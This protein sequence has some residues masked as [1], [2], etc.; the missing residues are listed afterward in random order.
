MP[1]DMSENSRRMLSQALQGQGPMT[2]R[3]R[4]ALANRQAQQAARV[5]QHIQSELGAAVDPIQAAADVGQRA[6][7]AAVPAYKQA[8]NQ[9]LTVSQEMQDIMGTPIFQTKLNEQ[10][11]E[12]AA[13]GKDPR[14]F[15]FIAQPGGNYTFGE[16]PSLEAVDK[17]IRKINK[18]IPRDAFGKPVLDSF[19]YSLHDLGKRMDGATREANPLFDIA[20]SNY[21][22]EM[23]IRQA[24]EQGQKVGRYSGHEINA[25]TRSMPEHAQE[26]WLSGASSAFSD[27]A[28]EKGLRPTANVAADTQRQIGLPGAGLTASQGDAVK[29]EALE[30][31]TGRPGSMGRLGDRLEMEDAAHQTFAAAQRGR[32]GKPDFGQSSGSAD[33]L[34]AG[35][36]LATGDISGALLSAFLRG[37]PKGTG[38]FKQEVQEQIADTLS[39]T[40]PQAVQRVMQAIERQT[41]ADAA[42]QARRGT[43]AVQMGRAG[44][45]QLGGLDGDPYDPR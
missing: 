8:Y 4:Q 33:L 23:A 24:L 31:L 19:N 35:L 40:D 22:D 13:F 7:A 30:N 32:S 42:K 44:A 29:L 17:V 37:N 20:K 21:A 36:G 28:T 10:A 18:D 3:A 41:A 25:Q 6:A 1:A 5:R 39:Q 14:D 12:L 9:G 26:A 11:Q 34:G 16:T 15:G 38:K 45:V 43:A 27:R 2:T